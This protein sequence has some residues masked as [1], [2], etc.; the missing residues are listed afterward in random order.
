MKN[1][2]L[3]V[4]TLLI[5]CIY[6]PLFSVTVKGEEVSYSV[7]AIIP[8]NQVDD[9][10]T[11]FDLKVNKNEKQQ[12]Q[13]VI[14]N[15]EQEEITV[16]LSVNPATT[17]S[18][19]LIVYDKTDELDPSL[20]IALPDILQFDTKTVTVPAGQSKT[21]SASLHTPKEQFNGVILGGLHFEKILEEDEK[22]EGVSI[23][24]KYAY[25]IGVQL[26]QSNKKVAPKLNLVSVR[27][28]LA[29]HRTASIATIQNSEPVIVENLDINIQV[30]EDGKNK[31][32]HK[33]NQEQ[34]KMAPNSNM[35]IV[36][37][38]DNQPLKPGKY[39][40]KAKAT[41]PSNTWEWEDTFTINKSEAKTLNQQAVELDDDQVNK[42][43]LL[44]TSVLVLVIISLLIYIRY[45]KYRIKIV[46][47]S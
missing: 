36:I 29:N 2:G 9:T 47:K 3:V 7:Q 38:W 10:K 37:D 39:A 30:Y 8:E 25:I 12:L 41:H 26:R 21:V 4:L 35:D 24:N 14:Y 32:I 28:D 34:I 20:Q 31:V 16:R 15:N 40:V 6:L 33:H 1:K 44:G 13:T 17:N 23:H 42:W 19:G 5:T 11:Y 27:P 22:S 43:L 46:K 18:N 45:L